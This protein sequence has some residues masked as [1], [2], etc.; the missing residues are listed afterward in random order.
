[1]SNVGPMHGAEPPAGV[2]YELAQARPRKAAKPARSGD[3]TGITAA[4]RELASASAVVSATQDVRSE[5]VQA[6]KA[7]I[8][9]GEYKPDPEAIARRLLDGQG[10]D[11]GA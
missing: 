6:L 9:S 3:A 10:G 7:Q 8:N 5:R 1:M 11:A 4:G 2:I